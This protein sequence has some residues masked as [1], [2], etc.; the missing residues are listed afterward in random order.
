M[1]VVPIRGWQGRV[2]KDKKS[3]EKR[4]RMIENGER[5]MKWLAKGVGLGACRRAV[6]T[7]PPAKSG[8]RPKHDKESDKE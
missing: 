6:A 5:V 3:D 7:P 8:T 4:R 2:V 1:S